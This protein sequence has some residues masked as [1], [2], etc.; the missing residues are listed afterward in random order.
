MKHPKYDAMVVV[1]YCSR[2][3]QPYG[4]TA[5]KQGKDWVFDWSFKLSEKALKHE[6]FSANKVSG[7]IF[8]AEKFP[9]C[10]HCGNQSWVQ[11]GQ[12]G[13]ISCYP[14]EGIFTCPVCGNSGEVS[15]GDNFDLSGGGY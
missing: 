6:G 11:C 14:G 15:V 3:K 9:G 5:I 2:N 8:H 1:A 13:K 4:I 10:P 12:C 7:N